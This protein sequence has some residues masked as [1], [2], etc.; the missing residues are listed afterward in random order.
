MFKKI[1]LGTV[2]AGVSYVGFINL[3][4]L[5][6]QQLIRQ[7]FFRLNT[8]ATV[9]ATL[10]LRPYLTL[11]DVR[12]PYL[13]ENEKVD[14]SLAQA[15]LSTC[16]LTLRP[17]SVTT[18]D[19][20]ATEM[21]FKKDDVTM[22]AKK[23]QGLF[24]IVGKKIVLSGVN[25]HETFFNNTYTN[26]QTDLVQA[27]AQADFTLNKCALSWSIKKLDVNAS[28]SEPLT[29][30]FPLSESVSFS[31]TLQASMNAQ[32]DGH[33]KVDVDN[34]GL[35][36]KDNTYQLKG[37]VS[38]AFNEKNII[39]SG[40]L[41][42]S[43]KSPSNFLSALKSSLPNASTYLE[44]GAQFLKQSSNLTVPVIIDNKEWFLIFYGFKVKVS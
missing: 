11:D 22:H 40:K 24:S 6:I 13:E 4:I 19:F 16:Q 38:V 29:S 21:S 5:S 28:S 18:F 12:F 23:A 10:G 27:A 8:Q 14:L 43:V 34:V 41:D 26:L 25:V 2:L 42:L 7:G 37:Q 20:V 44:A 33:Y 30:F 15:T 1:A 32:E 17:F 31:G 35:L 39:Q 3:E 36:T 9:K